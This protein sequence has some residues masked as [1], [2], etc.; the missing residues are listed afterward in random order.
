MTTGS[1]SGEM[2]EDL[3]LVGRR[4]VFEE[5]LEML[6]TVRKSEV[7]AVVISGP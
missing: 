2:A 7:G 6:R 4:G 5:L 3:P 1:I